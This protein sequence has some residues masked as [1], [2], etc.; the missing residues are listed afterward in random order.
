MIDPQNDFFKGGSMPVDQSET[1]INKQV[2]VRDFWIDDLTPIDI[3]PQSLG[4][5]TYRLTI[6]SRDIPKGQDVS[7]FFSPK[8]STPAIGQL[9]I[10]EG[11]VP[12]NLAG[13]ICHFSRYG[14][15]GWLII[16][17]LH[18]FH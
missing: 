7:L 8:K 16:R 3:K 4:P 5:G 15:C 12:K 2:A 17:I 11:N 13:H 9:Q 18:N 1:I 10:V 14:C 6:N